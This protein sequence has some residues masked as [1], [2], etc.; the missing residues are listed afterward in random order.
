MGSFFSCL[1]RCF[2][3]GD[4]SDDNDPITSIQCIKGSV[5]DH[6]QWEKKLARHL[7]GQF[8]MA[9][10]Q[11][12]VRNEDLFQLESGSLS[13]IVPNGP[14]GVFVGI[15]DGHGGDI[16]SQFVLNHLFNELKTAITNRHG[17][18]DET[19]IQEAYLST[20]NKFLELVTSN[21]RLIPF[22]E[23]M[24]S[25]C[26]SGVM[27]GNKLYVAN[28]GDSRAVVARWADG[29]EQPRVRQLSTDHN[30]NDEAIREELEAE[31]PDDPDLFRVVNGTYRIRDT[32]QVT[33]AIGDA[34]LKSNEFNCEP[35]RAR[36]R[37]QRPIVRPLLKAVPTIKTHDLEPNDRFVIFGSDGLWGEVTN[38]EAV[39]IVK[40]SSRSGAARALLKAALDKAGNRQNLEYQDLINLPLDD[41]RYHHDD[42]SIVI[43]FFDEL[44]EPVI[45]PNI[46]C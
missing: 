25:C 33:R 34:Y 1:F 23:T 4:E 36:Y 9:L 35:L 21:R 20:E 39:S 37:R 29:E 45:S 40:G 44:P 46:G 28:A 5:K 8:S 27:H 30:A 42:I 18:V 7:Y 31:H 19:V 3:S 41:K 38:E 16:C 13:N 6:Y 26:L 32:I 10:A 12:N 11:A 14:T 17:H 43:L 22:L 15:Y 2:T 24:G